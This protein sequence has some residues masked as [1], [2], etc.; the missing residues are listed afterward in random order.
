V[1]KKALGGHVSGGTTVKDMKQ[2]K[3]S[4][5]KAR[6]YAEI[7]EFWGEHDLSGFWE[8]NQKGKV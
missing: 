8:K 6:S 3:S 5:S 4:L 2:N 7:G 1:R